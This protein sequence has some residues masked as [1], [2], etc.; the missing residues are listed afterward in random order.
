MLCVADRFDGEDEDEL[1]LWQ[2]S[3]RMAMAMLKIPCRTGM[4]VGG[5]ILGCRGWR[6]IF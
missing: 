1:E 2:P 4:S 3:R 5:D 6:W